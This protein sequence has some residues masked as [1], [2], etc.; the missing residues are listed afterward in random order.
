M[1]I[2][3]PSMTL[4]FAATFLAT[5]TIAF[6][7]KGTSDVGSTRVE[8]ASETI[9]MAMS[10]R[11]DECVG[12]EC[13]HNK[14]PYCQFPNLEALL[15]DREG[16]VPAGTLE[17]KWYNLKESGASR[18]DEPDLEA[19]AGGFVVWLGE[20]PGGSQPGDKQPY[21]QLTNI[22]DMNIVGIP[23]IKVFDEGEYPHGDF[24]LL[25]DHEPS[26][27]NEQGD[28]TKMQLTKIDFITRHPDWN[29]GQPTQWI[30]RYHG[31]P[32]PWDGG[33]YLEGSMYATWPNAL[34]REGAVTLDNVEV[35]GRF[36]FSLYAHSEGT[37]ETPWAPTPGKIYVANIDVHCY[38]DHGIAH[39]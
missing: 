30:Q 2:K 12:D 6:A 14:E 10:A 1:T 5:P 17:M 31:E 27:K 20:N 9:E 7:S 19:R 37:G 36:V 25:P 26:D 13:L 33:E 34:G 15:V 8:L 32:S 39:R 23:R 3:R 11:V 29:E 28:V 35:T 4:L 38:S 16:G 24:H 21:L 22:H 18:F